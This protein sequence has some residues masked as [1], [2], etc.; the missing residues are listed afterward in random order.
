ML[1]I[2]HLFTLIFILL[3]T[4]LLS[5]CSGDLS[6]RIAYEEV[7]GL[8]KGAP[9]MHDGS[10]VGRV[11]D[12]LYTEQGNFL[13]DVTVQKAFA[14]LVNHS[15]L[16]Y[17]SDNE[18]ADAKVIELVEGEP[19]DVSSIEEGQIV[20][21]SNRF[22]GMAQKF[23]NQMGDTLSSLTD[24]VKNTM[25]QWKE[26]TLEQQMEYVESELD[27]LMAAIQDMSADARHQI[28]TQIIPE[29]NEQFETL[30]KKLEELGREDELDGI[31]Q[32]MENLNELIEA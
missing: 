1:R 18:A 22:T 10:E 20:Q 21:G 3:S 6:F 15:A 14:P 17:I 31:E 25:S 4:L 5:A 19:G 2:R 27:R 16:F 7:D 11:E 32:K 26:Q 28:E 8:T 29:L 24:S 30:K 9:V 12:I 23:Q 13:V